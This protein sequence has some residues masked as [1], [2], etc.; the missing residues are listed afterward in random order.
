MAPSA[1]PSD[2]PKRRGRAVIAKRPSI[3]RAPATQGAGG[4]AACQTKHWILYVSPPLNLPP[5]AIATT[6]RPSGCLR[7]SSSVFDPLDFLGVKIAPRRPKSR[8]RRPKTAQS[9]PKTPQSRPKTPQEAP[10]RRQN[11]EKKPKVF[12]GFCR[13]GQIPPRGAQDP[14]RRPQDGSKIAPH[15]SRWPR[16]GR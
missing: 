12:V 8:P 16:D 2:Q 13:S 14:P 6:A 5:T 7:A 1:S 4:C 11:R 3:R 10:R 15:C 9:R